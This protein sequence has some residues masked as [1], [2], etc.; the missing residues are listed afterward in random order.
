MT[1]MGAVLCAVCHRAV[2]A[3]HVDG[4]GRCCYCVGPLAQGSD[5]ARPTA[6]PQHGPRPVSPKERG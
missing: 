2:Y 6:E 4:E 5:V 3:V 1:E